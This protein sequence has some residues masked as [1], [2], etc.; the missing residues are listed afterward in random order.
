MFKHESTIQ[1]QTLFLFHSIDYTSREC[2]AGAYPIQEVEE[3]IDKLSGVK[4]ITMLHLD[5]LGNNHCSGK[6]LV[7]GKKPSWFKFYSSN[8]VINTKRIKERRKD[9]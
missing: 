1:R 6:V 7:K 5:F 3:F 2:P 8:Q 4:F 9:S